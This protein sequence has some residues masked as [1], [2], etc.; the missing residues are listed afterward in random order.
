MAPGQPLLDRL[1]AFQQPVHRAVEGVGVRLAQA[2]HLPQRVAQ[3][4]VAQ[5]ARGGQLGARRDD[6]RRDHG[7]NPFA[8]PRGPGG[9]HPVEAERAQEAQHGRDVAVGP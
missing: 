2:E 6:A 9:D 3:R 8:L 4:L 7:Q 1:L 5:P